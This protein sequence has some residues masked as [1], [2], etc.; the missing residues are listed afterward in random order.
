MVSEYL[1]ELTITKG[2][3]RKEL[4]LHCAPELETQVLTAFGLVS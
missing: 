1:W 2:A 4:L 3:A